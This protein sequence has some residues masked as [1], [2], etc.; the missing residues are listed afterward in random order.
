MGIRRELAKALRKV[1]EDL[2]KSGN[3][4]NIGSST[5]LEVVQT[6]IFASALRVVEFWEPKFESNAATVRT[7]DPR[8]TSSKPVEDVNGDKNGPVFT[9][10][11][12][13]QAWATARKNRKLKHGL[14]PLLS[15]PLALLNLPTVSP[16]HLK[17]AIS[18]LAPS[19]EIPPPR[20]R[21]NPGYYESSVQNGLPKLMLLAARV[22]SQVF[23]VEGTKWL[24]GITGGIDG[25]RGQLVAML[26]GVAGGITS[27]LEAASRSLYLTVEGRR[28]MLEE[29]EKG[30]EGGS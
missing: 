7:D 29:E 30:K 22:D 21:D 28:R 19:K 3:A 10:G 13:E 24:A 26:S 6:G 8:K 14:E 12:S 25:L 20:R 15:G 18:I 23:D 5:K 2:A 16:Q 17:A 1:D 27:T 4:A 9:H 11:L